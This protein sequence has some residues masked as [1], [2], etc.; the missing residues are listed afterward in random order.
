MTRIAPAVLSGLLAL[1]APV[2]CTSPSKNAPADAAHTTAKPAAPVGV[3]AT[4]ED[5][6]AHVKLRFDTSA[7]DVQVDIS[8][9]DGLAVTSAA[10]PVRGA[11][12]DKASTSEFDVA[13]NP[14]VGRSHLVVA[15][16][17]TFQG[18]Y[19]TKVASFSTGAPTVEQQ[20]SQGSVLTGDEGERLMVLPAA[21]EA[22]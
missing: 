6:K 7:S 17:G 12:F 20:K 11:S 1:M 19:M 5:G 10:T 4:L 22:Q 8:G 13:Y 3:S 15:I 14:G 9:V 21:P 18:S 2:A 16:R